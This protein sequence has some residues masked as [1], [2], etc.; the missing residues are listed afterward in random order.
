MERQL[1]ALELI[2]TAGDPLREGDVLRSLS[3]YHWFT[4][5]GKEAAATAAEAVALL[6]RLEPSPEL[7][8]A[9]SN[10]S[11]LRML[12]FDSKEAIAWGER[13]LELA[14]HFGVEETAVHALTNIGAAQRY[15]EGEQNRLA[16]LEESLAPGQ[17]RGTR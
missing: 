13:A 4:G 10:L 3:R 1:A 2:R 15:P 8:R 11:Q 9:Y 12:A 17:G 16:T 6:E 5:D 14:E 7:A